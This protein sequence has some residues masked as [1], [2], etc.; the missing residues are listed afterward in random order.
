MD[1]DALAKELASEGGFSVSAR[2]ARPRS[3]VMVSRVGD[4][5]RIPG[6]PSSDELAAYYAQVESRM[7]P[8]RYLGGWVDDGDTYIDV[9]NRFPAAGQQ[10]QHAL[11]ANEQLAGWD[12]GRS[13]EIPTDP[14]LFALE[15]NVDPAWPRYRRR[16]QVMGEKKRRDQQRKMVDA[17]QRLPG[18]EGW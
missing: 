12:V 7:G 13:R 6:I 17:Q 10:A 15:P 5:V 9:S 4:E 18:S 16:D 2:G 1:F 11:G 8:G 14:Q 3:G